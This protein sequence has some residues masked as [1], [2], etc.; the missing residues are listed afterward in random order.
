[1][2]KPQTLNFG[3]GLQTDELTFT[4]WLDNTSIT[5]RVQDIG[6]VVDMPVSKE[7]PSDSGPVARIYF[8]EH[9]VLVRDSRVLILAAIAALG[10]TFTDGYIFLRDAKSDGVAGGT[11]TNGAWRTRDLNEEVTDTAGIVSL[12]ANQMTLE[13]GD[14]V[15]DARCPANGV[16]G[17]LARLR[18]ITDGT[19]IITG[20]NTVSANPAAFNAIMDHASIQG[21]FSLPSQKVLEI[22]HVCQITVAG[23]GFGAV[24]FIF[25]ANTE[26]YTTVEI[27]RVII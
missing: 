22:Q 24:M 3:S 10:P 6:A 21:R 1:M 23:S 19:T 2:F 26:V 18:N 27:W 14:Y 5:I 11:F 16:F 4:T 12:S 25:E 20:S 17:H 13:A 8:G 7:F 15:I 9:Q